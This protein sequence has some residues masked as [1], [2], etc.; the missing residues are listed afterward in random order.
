MLAVALV[1][2]VVFGGVWD[3]MSEKVFSSRDV[4]HGD[5]ENGRV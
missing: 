2:D 1:V 3:W 5:D 4:N